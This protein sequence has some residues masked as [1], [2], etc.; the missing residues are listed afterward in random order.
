MSHDGLHWKNRDEEIIG[1]Q[2]GKAEEAAPERSVRSPARKR[3]FLG[4]V[5]ANL[6]TN[7]LGKLT[8]AFLNLVTSRPVR[9]LFHR[10]SVPYRSS[11][12]GLT[13]VIRSMNPKRQSVRVMSELVISHILLRIREHAGCPRIS[14]HLPKPREGRRRQ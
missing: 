4:P 6:R 13:C 2:E 5:S 11:L 10:S 12:R 9:R 1:S 8:E 7:S 14:R 3:R